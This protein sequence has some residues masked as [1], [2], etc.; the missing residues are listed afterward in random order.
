MYSIPLTPRDEACLMSQWTQF[1][2]NLP[3]ESRLEI[4]RTGRPHPPYEV[5]VIPIEEI[6]TDNSTKVVI[7]NCSDQG[8]QISLRGQSPTRT[9]EGTH[10]F[11]Q[12]TSWHTVS[13]SLGAQE[14]KE[15]VRLNFETRL[16]EIIKKDSPNPSLSYHQVI[17]NYI[18]YVW[19]QTGA[20]FY[21]RT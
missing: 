20:M 5:R 7:K 16:F 17:W 3:P 14:T 2:E 19:S 8:F 18:V 6:R 1:P 15:L 13:N 9:I 11:T 12:S 21:G 4:H 10:F